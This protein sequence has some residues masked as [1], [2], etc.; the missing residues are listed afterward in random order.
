MNVNTETSYVEL[1]TYDPT[2]DEILIR[3][4]SRRVTVITNEHNL[5]DNNGIT[6]KYSS[7]S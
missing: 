4:I 5:R 1:I 2:D 3:V 6:N 7:G